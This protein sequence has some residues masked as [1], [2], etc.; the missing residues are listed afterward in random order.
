MDD[1]A[2]RVAEI[3]DRDSLPVGT[4]HLAGKE[5]ASPADIA[6]EI[7]R[8]TNSESV[9]TETPSDSLQR[10]AKRPLHPKLVSTRETMLP[11]FQEAL[12]RFLEI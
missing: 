6:R 10:S 5:M 9:V 1:L 8:I 11:S 12:P 7:V 4:L 2:N 3:L